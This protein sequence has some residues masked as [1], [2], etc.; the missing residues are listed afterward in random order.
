[1]MAGQADKTRK[2]QDTEDVVSKMLAPEKV[3]EQ[4]LSAQEESDHLRSLIPLKDLSQG[5]TPLQVDA[6]SLQLADT[7][8]DVREQLDL[9]AFDTPVKNQGS[10]PWCTAF[11]TIGAVEN[12]GK[13]F[14]QTELDLS[15][16]HHFK[17]Y[18]VYQTSPSLN[19]ARSI[20]FID[21]VLWPY[22]GSKQP[23]A[24]SKVRAKIKASR[25]IQL[26]LSDVV[27]SIR[28]GEPVIINL[29]V[30][31][32]FMRPKA[33]GVIVPGGSSQGGH[34][35]ALTGVVLDDRVGGGGYFVIKNS[36]GSSWGDHGYGYV[37]F[38]YCQYSYC[39]AWA[40]S[41]IS[42]NDDGGKLRD[43]IPG[44]VPV[45]TPHPAPSPA[46]VPVPQPSPVPRPAPSPVPVPIPSPDPAPA[47]EISSSSF[48]LKYDI[49]DYRGLF[50]AHFFVLSIDAK[51]DVL[52][53]VKSV[54]YHVDG[55]R[56]FKALM[57]RDSAGAMSTISRSY[58]IWGGEHIG[59]DATV[60]LKD[61][62]SFQIHG[63]D[64]SL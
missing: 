13:K 24:D 16:I 45:P 18:G 29:D 44:V 19:A 48:T 1:M 52:S 15:E 4:E 59:S 11:A 14:F 12:L 53:Q 42:V 57:S 39:Y 38:S 58:K 32:S 55:Y 49:K 60:Y 5:E 50:G 56:D 37:P 9:R 51:A 62:R 35:I 34:A 28:N 25:K 36:W 33:G 30:N 10:R 63:I 20:G 46:P 64:V 47:G 3:P 61:G 17:S 6:V 7:S 26:N 31:S 54:V 27:S 8:M 43:K 21:E 2:F 41:D 23:G 22:Y 40:L